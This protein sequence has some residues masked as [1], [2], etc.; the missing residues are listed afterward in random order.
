M[1]V[2]IKVVQL[3]KC[4]RSKHEDLS[5][6]PGICI[7]NKTKQNKTKQNKTKQNKT[8]QKTKS[9][10]VPCNSSTGPAGMDRCLEPIDQPV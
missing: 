5:S 1:K 6:D 3:L 9:A 8:K 7:K 10:M 4:L 2:L